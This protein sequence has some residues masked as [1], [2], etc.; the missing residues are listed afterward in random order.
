MTPAVLKKWREKLGYTQASL[1][2]EIG[3]T[4]TTISRWENGQRA[5]PKMA[6]VTM[7]LIEDG[8]MSD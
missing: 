7:R 6:E 5:I 8:P 1:A 3:V 2:A 4:V